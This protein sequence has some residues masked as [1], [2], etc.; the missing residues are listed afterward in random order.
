MKLSALN[1]PLTNYITTYLSGSITVSFVTSA[2]NLACALS[3]Q[4]ILT[5]SST[6]FA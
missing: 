3:S 6:N 2:G 5:I 4:Q 1:T